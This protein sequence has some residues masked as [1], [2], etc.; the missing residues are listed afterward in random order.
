MVWQIPISQNAPVNLG[1]GDSALIMPNVAIGS[2][3]QGTGSSQTVVVYGSVGAGAGIPIKLGT[4]DVTPDANNRIEI[5]AGGSV[6]A[7]DGFWAATE[8][9]GV[10]H[11][12]VN[13][14]LISAAGVAISLRTFDAGSSSTKVINSGTIES[15]DYAIA[16]FEIGNVTVTN[17]GLI[18][19]TLRSYTG[20]NALDVITNSGRMVG[21]VFLFVG[22]D[23]YNGAA[24]QISGKVM[25]FHGNDVI[26]GGA[27]SERF[28]GENDSDTL[29]G[30]GGNDVLLGGNG[31]D[32]L[33]G[34][35]GNDS[36]NGGFDSDTISGGAGFDGVTGGPGND[37]FVFNAPAIFANRDLVTD[38]VNAAGNNDTFRLENAVMPAIGAA[39][40]LAAARFFVGA[41]ARDADDRIVYNKAT[42]ALFYDSNGVA[43]GGIFQLATLGNKAALTAADF[44]VI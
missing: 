7:P 29:T 26:T 5:K 30:N 21:D 28:E 18:S 1:F 34:G 16:A 38:F 32:T 39:G 11:T 25:G 44:V 23:V 10:A 15:I 24:G 19:S 8:L 12:L 3:V 14:G 22:N 2:T 17:S 35:L 41:A 20:N 9:T 42:G 13:A 31:N 27:G 6:F 43:A 33:N 4:Y 36:M 40:A 37:F